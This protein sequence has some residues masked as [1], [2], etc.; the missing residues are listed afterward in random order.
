MI[1]PTL[2]LLALFLY[3]AYC[4]HLIVIVKDQQDIPKLNAHL[5]VK[6]IQFEPILPKSQKTFTPSILE[7]AKYFYVLAPEDT[8]ASLQQEL[9]QQD[10]IKGAYIGPDHELPVMK[11]NTKC[12]RDCDTTPLF[13]DRQVYLNAA[14][15]G[16]DYK[17]ALQRKGGRGENVVVYDVEGGN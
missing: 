2:I 15:A 14:P 1:K 17:A 16:V 4:S 9:L 11:D 6:G 3:T 12:T 5:G 8:L 7:L 10:Y 13:V